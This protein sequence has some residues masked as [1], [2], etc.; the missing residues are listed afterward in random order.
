MIRIPSKN[1]KIYFLFFV[2]YNVLL[3]SAIILTKL[4]VGKF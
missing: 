2:L 4:F 1:I 3:F